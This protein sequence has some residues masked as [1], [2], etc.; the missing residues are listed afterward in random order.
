MH[1]TKLSPQGP[2]FSRHGSS[3]NPIDVAA[4]SATLV[5]SM[6]AQGLMP[7]E[8]DTSSMQSTVSEMESRVAETERELMQVVLSR[9]QYK[10]KCEELLSTLKLIASLH[11]IDLAASGHL[12]PIE[13]D[14]ALPARFR[15][16]VRPEKSDPPS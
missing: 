10:A 12:A 6:R 13:D 11:N 1:N 16:G 4:L 5:G 2:S 9:N 8:S 7:R 15:V 3:S 14:D